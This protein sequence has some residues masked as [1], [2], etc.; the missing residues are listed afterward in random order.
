MGNLSG[1]VPTLTNQQ[2]ADIVHTASVMTLRKWGVTFMAL[3]LW[4]QIM[5]KTSFLFG[6]VIPLQIAFNFDYHPS[7]NPWSCRGSTAWGG[8]HSKV[9]EKY[10]T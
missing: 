5:F 6:S 7:M 3:S 2:Q 9:W 8:V 1:S 4:L 10:F